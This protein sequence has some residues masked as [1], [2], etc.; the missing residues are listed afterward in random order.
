MP[1]GKTTE[2]MVALWTRLK[3]CAFPEHP[4]SN[5]SFQE[6]VAFLFDNCYFT[7]NGSVCRQIKGTPMGS[8]M[9]A[10][11]ANCFMSMLLI[12]FL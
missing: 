1:Q 6:T 8:N 9:S 12:A 2:C 5:E 7:F 11:A 4:L 3:E 10:V